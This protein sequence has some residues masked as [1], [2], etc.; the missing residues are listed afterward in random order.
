[1]T[2]LTARVTAVNSKDEAFFKALGGR[3]TTAR[4]A[5]ELTQIQLAEQ[6]GIVQ[7]TLAHYE[8]VHLRLPISMLPVLAESLSVSVEQLL[9]TDPDTVDQG[10]AMGTPCW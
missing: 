3:I 9:G 7:Q 5:Q 8:V 2:V 6:L 4:K 10:F 1:M